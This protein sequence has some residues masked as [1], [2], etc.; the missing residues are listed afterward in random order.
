M[1]VGGRGQNSLSFPIGLK[2]SEKEKKTPATGKTYFK[3]GVKTG[4][5]NPLPRLY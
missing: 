4:K 1:R 2:I 3:A 5:I